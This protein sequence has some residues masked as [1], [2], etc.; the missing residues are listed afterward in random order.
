MARYSLIH[1]DW[2]LR[3]WSD[4]PKTAV[5]IKNGRMEPLISKVDYV[6]RCCDGQ[7][8]FDSLLF[9]PVHI[10]I[11][12][13]LEKQG[14]TCPV[15][16]P[17]ELK[18]YQ[19][20]K[21]ADNPFIMNIHWAITG[22]CN[23]KCKHCYMEAPEKSFRNLSLK[24]IEK[25]ADEMAQ[26]N[27]LTINL[28]GGEPFLRKD[29]FDIIAIFQERHIPVTQLFTN[30]L[31]VDESVLDK[32]AEMGIK[33]GFNISF[34]MVGFHDKMRGLSGVEKPTIEAIKLLKKHDYNVVIASSVDKISASA[35]ME[36]YELMRDI[37]VDVWRVMSPYSTG[38]WAENSNLS[39]SLDDELN[40]YKPVFDQ[41]VAD[42][43]PMV[44]QLGNLFDGRMSGFKDYK[45]PREIKFTP[46]NYGCDTCK[47]TAYIDPD[48]YMLPCVAYTETDL[49]KDM[50][51]IFERGFADSFK[52]TTLR[53]VCDMKRKDLFEQNK[54]CESCDHFEK[55]GVGCR[56]IAYQETSDIYAIHQG[57]C[58]TFKNGY[59]DKILK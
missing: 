13:N 53:K 44:I 33:P 24:E 37:G 16:E 30:G 51:N 42:Q 43:Y 38:S 7:T 2:A 39:L 52:D 28:T 46:D 29:I 3:G 35:M 41:W 6:L 55:C 4:K 11:L 8:D 31:L 57:M 58:D 56:A 20:H 19:K 15:S 49:H 9:M 27:V 17:A 26:A 18:E 47:N 5:N 10:K 12:D 45:P 14:V 40:Y 25:Y 1:K 36:T 32:L 48:G 54:E 34:D 22:R 23:L 50:P 21:M 59:R